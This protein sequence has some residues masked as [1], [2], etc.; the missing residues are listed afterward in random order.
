MDKQVLVTGGSGYIAGFIIRQLAAEGWRINT[1][2][3]NLGR[4]GEV[5]RWLGVPDAQLRF[6]AADLLKDDGWAEAAAGCAHVVHVASPLPTAGVRHE[7]DLIV[8]AR[9]GALRALRAAKAAG[10]TRV[11]MTSS[12]AAIAY[13]H[14]RKIG[15]YTEADWTDVNGPQVHAYAKSKTLAE[16][17][18]RDWIAAEGGAM[19]YVSVNPAAVLGP[20]LSAD[21]SGSIEVVRRLIAGQLP[22]LPNFGFGVVDVRDVADLHVRALTASGVAGE[23]FIACGP[24]MMM[25]DI[26]AV[27]RAELG[28]QARKVPT[29]GLPDFVLR[30]VALFDPAVRMVTGELGKV[31]ETPADH[32][33][34]RLGW[35]PRPARDSIVDTARSLIDLGI[36]KL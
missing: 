13:G 5:R 24:F 18:A 35:V 23:R 32:A 36:V 14:G 8:P 11:V 26:A 6:F 21:F 10:A 15:R 25:K 7:D 17:A 27:L 34:D 30:A 16:R 20:V 3:R 22:G 29:R 28:G 1:T 2:I 9:D 31:R 19:E 12:V 4:E 33:R